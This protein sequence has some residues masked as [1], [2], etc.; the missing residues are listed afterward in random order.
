MSMEWFRVW[1]EMPND[2]KWRTIARKSKQPIALVISVYVHMLAQAS[3]TE[4][5]GRISGWKDD[6][7]ASALDVETEQVEAIYA[8]MQGKVLDGDIITGWIKRQPVREDG[9]S[10]ARVQAYRERRK[11]AET[12]CNEVKR[13]E[14][15][16]NARK[17]TREEEDKDADTEAEVGQKREETAQAPFASPPMPPVSPVTPTPATATATEATVRLSA[18]GEAPPTP[19]AAKTPKPTKPGKSR[20]PTD[21][22][23]A[24]TTY[25][26]LEKHGM[27]RPFAE[28]C[29]DE[30]R[31]YWQE[32]GES[33]TGWEA[34]FV[35]NVKRQWEHR[36]PANPTPLNGQRYVPL[37]KNARLLAGNQSAIE[38]WLGNRSHET[39]VIE[40]ECHE[41]H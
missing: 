20:I 16:G 19:K 3:T 13:D 39:H 34:T 4:D 28:G 7:I 24:E 27:D 21:W 2:P 33:R 23:P 22:T 35:N 11:Q 1:N 15:H 12:V 41:V 25:A 32:R 37:D 36:P 17:R 9:A 5:R 6:D 14:T 10:T 40:G 18:H 38:E 30:F 29:I 8:A 26:L 31:L